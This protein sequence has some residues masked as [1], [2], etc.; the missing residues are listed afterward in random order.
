[1]NDAEIRLQVKVDGSGAE[2]SL[3][4]L[5]QKATN[6]SKSFK[7][8]GKMM[9]VG[10]TAPIVALGT[11][12]VKGA[13]ELEA[14]EAKYNTVFKG[15]TDDA[16]AFIKKFQ[17]LTPATTASARSMASGIQDLLVPMGFMREEATSMT[18]NTM[19]LIGAL[20]NFN[21]ATHSAEDVSIAFQGALTGETQSL[22]RL[23][24]QV[25]VATIEQRAMAKT[26]KKNTK[27]LTKQDKAV[28]LME[29]AYEQSTDALAAYN[30]E[31]LDTKTKLDIATKG[32]QDQMAILGDKLIPILTDLVSWITKLTDWFSNLDEDQ[33][34]MLLDR[35]SVV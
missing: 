18:S 19:H 4:S 20:T 28:A 10:L 3:D 31:S 9:T 14:T 16:D 22:K 35:K 8:A 17:E 5:N 11:A 21:S 34:K 26:G 2:R 12:A 30:E 29:L 24:I 25:D 27:Q 6:L 1:M 7:N 33:Q 23:G 15:M 13:L 32:F